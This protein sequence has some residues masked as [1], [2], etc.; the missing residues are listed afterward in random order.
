MLSN[1]SNLHITI[2]SAYIFPQINK[3]FSTLSKA[4][5]RCSTHETARRTRS[6]GFPNPNLVKQ[7]MIKHVNR[8]LRE[9]FE[10]S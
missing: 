3:P 5:R 9:E 2:Q 8:E 4:K 10:V 1:V 7:E 6:L